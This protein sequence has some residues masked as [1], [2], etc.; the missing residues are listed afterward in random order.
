MTE[1]RAPIVLP[2]PVQ[3]SDPYDTVKALFPHL[4]STELYELRKKLITRFKY[5]RLPV[6]PRPKGFNQ[7]E[8]N[9]ALRY[10][11]RN[12]CLGLPKDELRRWIRFL[13]GNGADNDLE[14]RRS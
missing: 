11:A 3:A 9:Q 5:F 1:F 14:E 12:L 13:I 2:G 6:G 10:I 7:A 4:G 8:W